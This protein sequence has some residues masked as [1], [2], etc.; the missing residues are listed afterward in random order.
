[1]SRNI[2]RNRVSQCFCGPTKKELKTDSC[3]A[4]SAK[5]KIL[6]RTANYLTSAKFQCHSHPDATAE[7]LSRRVWIFFRILDVWF[8]F[9]SEKCFLQAAVLTK[10]FNFSVFLRL[11]IFKNWNKVSKMFLILI[12]SFLSPKNITKFR[13]VSST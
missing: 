1:M 9:L 5:V 2:L 7:A 4:R 13:L 6:L 10:M 12:F 3:Q 8:L 11:A